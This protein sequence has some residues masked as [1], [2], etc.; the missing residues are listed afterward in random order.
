MKKSMTTILLFLSLTTASILILLTATFVLQTLNHTEEKAPIAKPIKE[1]IEKTV[2]PPIQVAKPTPIQK[3]KPKVVEP[4]TN[5]ET[6]TNESDYVPLPK[7]DSICQL[8]LPLT[9]EEF[10]MAKVAWKYFEN[11]YNEKTGLTNA[12]HKYPSAA[13]WDWANGLYAMYAA[14]SFGIIT[15]ERYEKMMMKFLSTM[16]K[17]ELFN[18]ELPN[19]TY[20][21]R[22]AKMT[23]YVNKVEK[24]GTGWSAADLARMLS[25]LHF[26]N[27]CEPA[28]S[29]EIQKL[30]LRYRYCRTLSVEGDLYGGTYV[31]GKLHIKHEALTGYEEYLGRGFGLWRHNASEAAKYKFVKEVEVEGIKIPTDTRP[32]FS[33]FVESEPFWYLGFEY[34]KDD[35]QTGEYIHNIYKV[36]EKRYEKTGQL[37]AVTE[38]NID[39]RPYFLFNTIYTNNE[40]WK[41]INQHGDDYDGYKT[42]S[43]KAAFGMKY[44]FNTPYANKVFNY[45]RNN[46]DPKKGY[47]A[48]IYEKTAGI[49]KSMT[50][51]TNAIILEAMLSSKMGSLQKL[52]PVKQTKLFDY[53]SNTVNNFR[54]LP[55]QKEHLVL[56]PYKP[57]QKSKI[58]PNDLKAA[59]KAWQYFEKNYNPSTGL[60]NS[61]HGYSIIRPEHIGKT[62]MATL[63][64]HKLG[65]IP[66]DKFHKRIGTLIGALYKMKP[67]R[68]ELPNLYYSAKTVKQV[69]KAGKPSPTGNGWDLYSIAH[70]LTGLYHLEQAYPNYRKGIYGLLSKWNFSRAILP[71]GMQDRW[72]NGKDKGGFK[73]IQD[74]A[75]EFY[76]HNALSLFNIKSYSHL[77]DER[78]LDYKPIYNHEVPM[79]YKDAKANAESY[80]WS[81]LEHPY[82]LKYK[83]YSSNIYLALKD[84]YTIAKKLATS[85][86]EALD[87]KPYAIANNIY[88][89]HKLWVDADRGGKSQK[90]RNVVSTKVA[91]I[92][93]A[94]YGYADPYSGVL[95]N[96]LK[97]AQSK[98]KGWFGGKYLHSKQTNKSLNLLTNAAILEA[99]YYKKV[100][101]FYYANK[102]ALYNKIKLH[103]IKKNNVYSI[104][105]QPIELRYDAQ[106]VM[107]NLKDQSP[108]IRVE[109][110]KSGDD[111]I[112]KVGMFQ[113]QNQAKAYLQKIKK[114]M[115]KATIHRNNVDSKNFLLA[116]RYYRYEYHIPYKNRNIKEEN[117]A[118]KTYIAQKKTKKKAP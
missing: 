67:Y 10:K 107:E 115:P 13:T 21:T 110:E 45:V 64:A 22:S 70:M 108:L 58:N 66:K 84:R 103:K 76:I 43:T 50:L 118:Y 90:K 53:Y 102:P 5:E 74:P 79:G 75:K 96:H 19:K 88:D 87:R 100:G 47:Y 73:P 44:I 48:G 59:K 29:S 78:N 2:Q 30:A 20:N 83:H 24:E 15:Q 92:Y 80:L 95:R 39:R 23:N 14:K 65:I 116:N 28:L 62:I 104:Q 32:F 71:K 101:N 113:N 37:T 94:L 27:Q 61:L 33:N 106:K 82:F 17:M 105:S 35:K 1:P 98:D 68:K 54:C 52:N 91:F 63:A 111:F 55:S 117:S 97:D 49:N 46:Y 81:M 12:G 56:E 26:V 72:F 93:D 4:T 41:T 3:T 69:T 51:N 31:N 8:K 34:G 89:N 112:V 11:N 99:I 9:T 86:E 40:P 109:R 60:V 16:Q 36:Q 38:D 57:P 77:L 114:N 25:A 6:D 42:V 85:S 18:N 7:T